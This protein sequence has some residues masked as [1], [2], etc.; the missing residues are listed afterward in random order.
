MSEDICKYL[1]QS[2]AAAYLNVSTS[3]FAKL[4]GYG[5]RPK[6]TKISR[7]AIRYRRSDLD[8][9][10]ARLVRSTSENPGCADRND[11]GMS[12]VGRWQWLGALLRACSPHEAAQL[13]ELRASAGHWWSPVF[14]QNFL[15]QEVRKC[16]K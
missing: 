9:Y 4:R 2:E 1:K 7:A 3:T 15:P 10:M 8:A 14:S 13:H 16:S 6:L 12:C 5:G 11:R